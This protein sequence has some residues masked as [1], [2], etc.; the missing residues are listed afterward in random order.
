MYNE[1]FAR[2]VLAERARDREAALFLK[3]VDGYEP[4]RPRRWVDRS[5]IA[6]VRGIA[7]SVLRVVVHGPWRAM[8]DDDSCALADM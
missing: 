2:A 1:A 5:P 8:S 4:A 7:A 6:Y 3:S